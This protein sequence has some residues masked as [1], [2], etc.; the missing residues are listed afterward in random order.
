MIKLNQSLLPFFF[1]LFATL[2]GCNSNSKRAALEKGESKIANVKVIDSLKPQNT[3]KLI[4][5]DSESLKIISWNIQDLGRTKDSIEILEI[6]KIIKDFDIVA[7]QEVVAKDPAGAQAVAKIAD[8]LNRMG[9]KWDYS[10]SPPTK[11]PSAYMSE[12]YAFIWKTSKVSLVT[13]AFLDKE[14]EQ[15][16]IREPYIAK[17]KLKKGSEPYIA[18][19]KLKKGSEP[20]YVV[21]FHSRKHDDHL[22]E[23]II[24]FNE[25][26]ERLNSKRILIAGDFNLNEEHNVWSSLYQQGYKSALMRSKTTLKRKCKGG[27][28]LSH[29]IDNIYYSKGLKF[30]NSGVIDYVEKCQNLKA[31]RSISDHLPVFMEFTINDN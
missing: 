14:L 15:K 10:I 16:C 31:S 28:Y 7:I 27:D 20:F 2:L 18:K 17:F 4:S 8:E 25:Y 21:N 29:D 30:F 22:E 23:E 13:K 24:F 9:S 12:R 26:P 1:F 11:S 6:A 19:F 5:A 3:D